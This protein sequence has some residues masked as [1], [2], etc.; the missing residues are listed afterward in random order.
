[1]ID[2]R[3]TSSFHNY[4][5]GDI[6]IY[7]SIPRLPYIIWDAGIKLVSN[8]T[9]VAIIID[10]PEDINDLRIIEAN[11]WGVK[12]NKLQHCNCF[13]VKRMER[14]NE[15]KINNAIIQIMTYLHQPYGYIRSAV[16]AGIVRLIGIDKLKEN[17]LLKFL[18]IDITK[19]VIDKVWHCSEL[20]MLFLRLCGVEI[21]PTI[22]NQYA[23]PDDFMNTPILNTIGGKNK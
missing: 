22:P 12:I 13:T 8:K 23:I 11:F 14:I 7:D 21:N 16:L 20:V 4:R 9:H 1:M 6:V 5:R 17:K 18:N 2:A 10:N 19:S 3:Q 15:D